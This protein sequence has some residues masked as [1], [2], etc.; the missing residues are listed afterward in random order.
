MSWNLT[1]QTLLTQCLAWTADISPVPRRDYSSRFSVSGRCECFRHVEKKH[2]IRNRPHWLGSHLSGSLQLLTNF[3][4]NLSNFG[5]I[6]L[7]CVFVIYTEVR[8]WRFPRMS[9][10]RGQFS[11]MPWYAFPGPFSVFADCFLSKVWHKDLKELT[12]HNIR[13]SPCSHANLPLFRIGRVAKIP[14]FALVQTAS[15]APSETARLFVF[16]I[17]AIDKAILSGSGWSSI[18]SLLAYSTATAS[19]LWVHSSSFIT[20]LVALDLDCTRG[21]RCFIVGTYGMPRSIY[22]AP[23]RTFTASLS[24]TSDHT[25]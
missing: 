5:R 6:L 9:I 18:R 23:N 10:L 3:F 2:Y 11:A 4:S 8:C 19:T 21:S 17:N 14:W 20:R 24:I 25:R 1:V 15:T 12:S 16:L 22:G 13:S 7:L